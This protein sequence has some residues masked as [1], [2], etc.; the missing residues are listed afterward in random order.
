MGMKISEPAHFK[1]FKPSDALASVVGG[2]ARTL[3]R[4]YKDLWAYIKKNT[5]L[6]N[7]M[8]TADDKLLK[9]F[10]GAKTVPMFQ[11]HKFAQKHWT[12]S[13]DAPA[14]PGAPAQPQLNASI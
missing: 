12:E 3:F 1:K 13:K 8:V 11:V 9:V 14:Q 10:G 6:K 4:H 7:G 5:L 2:N